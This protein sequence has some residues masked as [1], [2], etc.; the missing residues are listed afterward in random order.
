M[1]SFKIFEQISVVSYSFHPQDCSTFLSRVNHLTIFGPIEFFSSYHGI[2][3]ST[4]P[5]KSY[6][7]GNESFNIFND[8]NHTTDDRYEDSISDDSFDDSP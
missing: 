2:Y 7:N 5:E 6:K 8:E 4:F 1:G 3:T